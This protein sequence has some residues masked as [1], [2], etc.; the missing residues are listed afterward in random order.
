MRE[1]VRQAVHDQAPFPPRH[2]SAVG[3]LPS[4]IPASLPLP[5]SLSLGPCPPSSQLPEAAAEVG[6]LCCKHLLAEH[7][8]QP[9]STSRTGQKLRAETE[10]ERRG[11][12]LPLSA[13]C[14]SKAR[15]QRSPGL[16]GENGSDQQQVL[17]AAGIAKALPLDAQILVGEVVPCL[18]ESSAAAP[19]TSEPGQSMF[20]TNSPND[21]FPLLLTSVDPFLP[22]S[23]EAHGVSRRVCEAQIRG[24][25]LE[26]LLTVLFSN[27]W[28]SSRSSSS[29]SRSNRPRPQPWLPGPSGMRRP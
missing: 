1:T 23:R 13:S 10:T 28:A 19:H 22:L 5:L 15:A 20:R 27:P 21:S 3:A 17:L 8:T 16:S 7:G 29:H 14:R 6:A 12:V 26:W 18:A 4:S 9:G 11:L 25:K 24:R 2:L